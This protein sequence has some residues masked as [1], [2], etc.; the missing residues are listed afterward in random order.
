[1]TTTTIALTGQFAEAVLMT[2]LLQEH[3]FHPAPVQ[4]SVQVSS[5]IQFCITVPTHEAREAVTMLEREGFGKWL[6]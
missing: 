5:E 3:S 1:M 6:V 2:S 4:S